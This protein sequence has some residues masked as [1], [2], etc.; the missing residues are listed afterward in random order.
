MIDEYSMLRQ[1]D[2]YFIDKR[3]QQIIVNNEPF[4]G[5]VV[6]LAGDPAQLPQVKGKCLWDAKVARASHDSNG[7]LRD[8]VGH[9]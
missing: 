8:E 1:C 2:L 4:G 9:K 6:V 3:L 5:L 7:S